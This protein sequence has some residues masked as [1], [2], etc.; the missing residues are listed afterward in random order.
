MLLQVCSK[1]KLST[2]FQLSTDLPP[3]N[4]DDVTDPFIPSDDAQSQAVRNHDQKC[5]FSCFLSLMLSD[6]YRVCHKFTL[7]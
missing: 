7:T 1:A 5:N 6:Y 4:T 3:K 2:D